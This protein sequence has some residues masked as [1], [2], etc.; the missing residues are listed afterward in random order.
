MN[1]LIAEFKERHHKC[2]YEAI[3]MVPPPAKKACLEMAQE[4][5]TRGAPPMVVPQS[6]VAGPSSAPATEKEAGLTTGE[7]PG[8]AAPVER[9]S[10]EKDSPV[11][12]PATPPSWDEMMEMLKHVPCF[13]DSEAPY[14]KMS[15]FFPLTKRI[16]VNM[17]DDPPSFVPAPLPFGTPKS[18]VFPI[19]QLQEW[20]VSETIEVVIHFI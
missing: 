12:V 13:T 6:N 2:L 9:V 8:D 1:D 17:G 18:V 7:A 11:P 3:D 4:K 14:T 19:Q 20:T 15:D 5:P 10:D 16:S